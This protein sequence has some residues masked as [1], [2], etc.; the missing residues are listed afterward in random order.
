[1]INKKIVSLGMLALLSVLFIYYIINNAD[2]FRIL[3]KIKPIYI[4][5]LLGIFILNTMCN[6]LINKYLLE[7]FN[8]YLSFKEWF[9]LAVTTSFYNIITPFRG[10]ALSKAAYL[11]KKHRFSYMRF[12]SSMIGVYVIQFWIISLVGLLTIF[13]VAFK[14]HAFSWIIL[15]LFLG[16]FSMLTGVIFFKIRLPSHKNKIIDKIFEIGNG[17]NLI[18]EKK[19]ILIISSIIILVQIILGALNSILLYSAV[20][21]K[22]NI[23]QAIFLTTI[24][25]VAGLASITPGNLGISEAVGVLS[26]LVLG[27]TP[28]QS[29]SAG[30]LGR[31]VTVITLFILGPIFSYKLIKKPEIGVKNGRT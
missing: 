10:G 18:R 14:Y 8:V 4:F 3:A 2:D 15:L 16:L 7:P 19:K 17:W 11:K 5:G 1:M 30:I 22:I 6:G 26:A 25:M 23:L 21:V 28:T 27:I 9:G 13:I 29:L 24:G 12:I 31:V 20:G